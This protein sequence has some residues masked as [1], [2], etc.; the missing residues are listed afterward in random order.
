MEMKIGMRALSRSLP[1]Q[2]HQGHRESKKVIVLAAYHADSKG[3]IGSFG[4]VH[5][6]ERAKVAAGVNLYLGGKSGA[7]RNEGDKARI[8]RHYAT[9]VGELARENFAVQAAIGRGGGIELSLHKR[10]HE[11]KRV[12]LSMRMRHGDA[13]RGA[14]VLKNQHVMDI[15]QRGKLAEAARPQVDYFSPVLDRHFRRRQVVIRMVKHDIA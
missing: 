14:R 4:G 7:K 11:G 6:G 13:D 3:K 12:N 10:R 5:V 8:L 2:H 9:A 1:Q 15:R